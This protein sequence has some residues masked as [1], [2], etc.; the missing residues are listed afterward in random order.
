[1]G[2]VGVTRRYDDSQ[3]IGATHTKPGCISSIFPCACNPE[4]DKKSREEMKAFFM[5]ILMR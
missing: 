2:W 1:M 5:Q 4:A 3:D